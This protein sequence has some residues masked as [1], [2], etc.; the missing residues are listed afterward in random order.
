MRWTAE[1]HFRNRVA[2]S[3]QKTERRVALSALYSNH[4]T[5]GALSFAAFAKGVPHRSQHDIWFLFGDKYPAS[6]G[7]NVNSHECQ[8]KTRRLTHPESSPAE[9]DGR[10]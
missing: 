10:Q 5:V 4:H 3:S 1:I 2:D 6:T 7:P 9:R 8:R